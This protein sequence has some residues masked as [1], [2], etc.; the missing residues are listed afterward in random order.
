MVVWALLADNSHSNS[1]YSLFSNLSYSKQQ[2]EESASASQIQENDLPIQPEVSAS[3]GSSSK[4]WAS[5]SKVTGENLT[6]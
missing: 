5:P 4:S 2:P 3:E 6:E 1:P